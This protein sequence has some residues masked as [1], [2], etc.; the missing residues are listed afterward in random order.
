MSCLEEGKYLEWICLDLIQ[1]L[2]FDLALVALFDPMVEI[3]QEPYQLREINRIEISSGETNV[4]LR[5][6]VVNGSLPRLLPPL[7]DGAV[8]DVVGR[9]DDGDFVEYHEE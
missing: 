4:C 1:W 9:K 3:D 8:H 2:G 7:D 6:V 5:R